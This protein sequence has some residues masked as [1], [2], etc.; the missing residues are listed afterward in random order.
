MGAVLVGVAY[1][2]HDAGLS[3]VKQAFQARQT[4]MK[5]QG[6]GQRQD[7][8][9]WNED[10]APGVHQVI[11]LVEWNEGVQPVIAA[12]ELDQYQHL[13]GVAEEVEK[14]GTAESRYA[15]SAQCK[16]A[17]DAQAHIFQE[18]SSVHFWEFF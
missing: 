7:L 9:L 13:V 18:I 4:W 5:S 17:A 14:S 8:I 3:V 1:A 15:E 2:L 6:V 11:V 16:R 12:V 10:V